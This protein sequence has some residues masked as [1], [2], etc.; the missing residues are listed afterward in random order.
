MNSNITLSEYTKQKYE[1]AHRV[2]T[3]AI[4]GHSRMYLSPLMTKFN[5]LKKNS[6]HCAIVVLSY[7]HV[8]LASFCDYT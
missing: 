1:K 2:Q 7:L 4:A 8:F 3:F 5:S 6:Q